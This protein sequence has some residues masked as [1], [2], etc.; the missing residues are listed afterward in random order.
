MLP[1]FV[2]MVMLS[3]GAA[4]SVTREEAIATARAALAQSEGLREDQIE[5]LSAV[6]QE[7]PDASLGCAEKGKVYAP[8]VTRGYRVVLR[9]ERTIQFVH[10]S[11]DQAV[12]CGRPLVAAE[13]KPETAE[14]AYEAAAPEPSA[15]ALKAL[16]AQAR[17]DLARR[18][19]IG[20]DDISLLKLK[21]FVWPDRS[22]G[23]PRPGMVYPQVPQD[24][25]LIVL[26]AAGRSYNYHAGSGRA[27][28]L[29][30]DPGAR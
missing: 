21:D 6:P 27:P 28:F 25:V 9:V 2:A 17:E 23:C 14:D 7:W 12:I 3:A 10:V 18:L 19:S 26:R 29:C 5:V 30:Q 1:L 22:L 13:L 15:P 20:P 24:G 4:E 16:V 11:G 8:A